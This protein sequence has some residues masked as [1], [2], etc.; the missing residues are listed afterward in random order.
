MSSNRWIGVTFGVALLILVPVAGFNYWADPDGWWATETFRLR[1]VT[2]GSTIEHRRSAWR[3][4]GGEVLILGSS[5]VVFLDWPR[6]IVGR[7]V[8]VLAFGDATLAQQADWWPE[9]I[10]R[11]EARRIYLGL[12][13]V[14][15]MQGWEDDRSW[16]A[17][18]WTPRMR[19]LFHY[20]RSLKSW[21]LFMR[22]ENWTNLVEG[23]V[24]LRTG[25]TLWHRAQRDALN[26][27]RSL[28]FFRLRV[29]ELNSG[30]RH[31]MAARARAALDSM[32]NQAATA[33]IE[34]VLFINPVSNRYL[35]MLKAENCWDE[36]LAWKADL[37]ARHGAIDLMREWPEEMQDWFFDPAHLD[38]AHSRW[39]WEQLGIDERGSTYKSE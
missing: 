30:N 28:R 17:S 18:A 8:Q 27:E 23:V 36:V 13:Y 37:V 2:T 16:L 4:H 14:G 10:A 33:G 5:R 34:V 12:D 22:P 25:H 35:D 32:L 29:T 7:R 21:Q 1:S 26:D 19:A 39:M 20:S 38:F 31:V 24:D 6:S 15:A 9:I 11:G 3:R